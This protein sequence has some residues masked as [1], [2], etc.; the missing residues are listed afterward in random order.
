MAPAFQFSR[1]LH[2]SIWGNRDTYIS[3]LFDGI[4]TVWILM[5]FLWIFL[6]VNLIFYFTYLLQLFKLEFILASSSSS[7]SSLARPH[8]HDFFQRYLLRTVFFRTIVSR[9]PQFEYFTDSVNPLNKL[10]HLILLWIETFIPHLGLSV[11]H[12]LIRSGHCQIPILFVPSVIY[13]MSRKNLNISS[14]A[15]TGVKC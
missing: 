14:G 12:I 13:L 4:V 11:S 3:C 1:P 2:P 10:S 8:L 5:H 15:P 9:V 6:I 7:S